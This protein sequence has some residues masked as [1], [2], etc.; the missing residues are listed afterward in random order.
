MANSIMDLQ[1][2][3][4]WNHTWVPLGKLRS[5]DS[6][7]TPINVDPGHH[8]ACSCP[9]SSILSHS[10]IPSLLWVPSSGH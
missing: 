7:M 5:D 8:P 3:V 10:L 2:E 4:A 1:P 6:A 9:L